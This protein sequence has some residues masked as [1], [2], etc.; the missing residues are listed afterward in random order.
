MS[1]IPANKPAYA[2][3][4]LEGLGVFIFR[5]L[6]FSPSLRLYADCIPKTGDKLMSDPFVL[7]LLDV[8]QHRSPAPEKG[9]PT[10]RGLLCDEV[11]DF[12]PLDRREL[13]A[14]IDANP[15]LNAFA[16]TASIGWAKALLSRVNSFASAD[17]PVTVA[18]G[19]L[20][21]LLRSAL[22]GV[23]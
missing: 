15:E 9:E 2:A 21:L 23:R 3:T 8:A 4:A 1:I 18:V 7:D 14:A 22:R 13:K 17:E 16:L 10:A 19:D 12:S 6:L 5:I 20:L 11:E